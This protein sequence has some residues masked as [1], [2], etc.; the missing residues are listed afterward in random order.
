MRNIRNDNDSYLNCKRY[1]WQTC[2]ADRLLT[3]RSGL[4]Q[5]ISNLRLVQIRGHHSNKCVD[6]ITQKL[7]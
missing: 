4:P 5:K 6:I 2:P 1:A 3:L 7:P